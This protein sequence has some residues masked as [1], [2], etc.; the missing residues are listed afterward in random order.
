MSLDHRQTPPTVGR[1]VERVWPFVELA[2]CKGP[3]TRQVVTVTTPTD[4]PRHVST[5]THW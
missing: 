3:C 2:T 5:P 1:N 4:Q